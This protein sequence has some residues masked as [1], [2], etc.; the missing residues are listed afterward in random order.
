[1][2]SAAATGPVASRTR[3]SAVTPA[4]QG[5]NRIVMNRLSS[6]LSARSVAPSGSAVIAD[7]LPVMPTRP[8]PHAPHE[9]HHY[10]R[11]IGQR[12]AP[13]GAPG[14]S[15]AG[16]ADRA[17]GTLRFPHAPNALE[18]AEGLANQSGPLGAGKAG[19]TN[20]LDFPG[21]SP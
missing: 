2:A 19:P 14:T 8:P 3:P 7:G 16:R 12:P 13:L 1:M 10:R 18:A 6:S 9:R 20:V 4:R 15:R 21:V 11:D 17:A 5:R